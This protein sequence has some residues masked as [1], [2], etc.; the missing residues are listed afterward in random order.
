MEI[1]EC[2]DLFKRRLEIYSSDG[3]SYNTLPG[4]QNTMAEL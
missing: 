1:S 4:S 2:N 3:E